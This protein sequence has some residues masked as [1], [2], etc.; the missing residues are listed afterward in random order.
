MNDIYGN[1]VEIGDAWQLDGA[2]LEIEDGADLVVTSAVINY[3]RAV[4][5][6]TPLN[7]GKRYIVT[8]EA[9]GTLQLG[10]IIGPSKGIKDFI[11]R[12]ATACNVKR[13]TITIKPAGLETCES[14]EQPIAFVCKGLLISALSVSVSQVGSAMTVVNAGMSMNFVSLSL[15]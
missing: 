4:S 7:S 15:D 11:T 12:Y 1:N 10:A 9:N 3:A 13:N 8:G 6:F 2:V 14:D 5:K